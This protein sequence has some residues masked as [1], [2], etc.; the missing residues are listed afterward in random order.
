M[1][2]VFRLPFYVAQ[3]FHGVIRMLKEKGCDVYAAHLDGEVFYDAD[4]RR[5][6]A[7][8]IGNEG[9]GLTVQTALLAD[10]Q[11][12]IPMMG[13]VESLNASVAA[14]LIMYEVLRQRRFM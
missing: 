8:L 11:L 4:F 13:K 2:A 5:P 6:C 1:G 12:R 3:D 14:S 9:R 7:F 10:Y